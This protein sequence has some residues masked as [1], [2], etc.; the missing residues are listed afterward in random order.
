MNCND[1]L[2]LLSGHIDGMNTQQEE[3]DLR[4][5]LQVCESCRAL[6]DE[7]TKNDGILRSDQIE[8]PP[9]LTGKIMAEVRKTKKS[10]RPFYI[11]LAASGLAAAAVLAVAFSGKITPPA[12][13]VR[14]TDVTTV[15]VQELEL[16]QPLR[17]ITSP[18]PTQEDFEFV[19]AD[20][21][22]PTY[23]SAGIGTFPFAAA[24][25][26]GMKVAKVVDEVSVLVIRAEPSEVEF[27]GSI[28]EFDKRLEL[29]RDSSYQITGDEIEFYAVSWSTM[30]QL[31][32][33]YDGI[34]EME[35][36]Y[37]EDVQYLRALVVF[38]E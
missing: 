18:E 11:S 9:G 10:K 35:K 31:A 32:A 15:S 14:P 19:P 26:D 6:L 25:P 4:N 37:L 24:V 27:S 12:N 38:A 34:F 2:L 5:H 22:E 1:Y 16:K 20:D 17:H 21:T 3:K 29:L 8:V 23:D 28:P 36:Y 33:D 30:Q 13:D 7:M